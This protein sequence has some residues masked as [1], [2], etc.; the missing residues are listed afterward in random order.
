MNPDTFE[1][2]MQ[3]EINIG[4]MAGCPI[5]ILENHIKP[6]TCVNKQ[7]VLSSLVDRSV[8]D[9]LGSYNN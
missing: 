7:E 6:L 4:F 1:R 3:E 5:Q 8:I 9:I 2:V